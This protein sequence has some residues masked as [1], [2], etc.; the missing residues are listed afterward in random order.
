MMEKAR[1]PKTGEHVIFLDNQR[2]PHDALVTAPWSE[3]CI[4]LVL[5]NSD[6]KSTDT[7]GRQIARETSCVHR[8][9]ND[10]GG[11][12]WAFPEEL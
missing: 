5:V 7:Y 9:L 8:S 12:C 4:N 6:E 10:A 1:L 3:T 11:M 2:K